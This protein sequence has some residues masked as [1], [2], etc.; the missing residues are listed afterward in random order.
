M[1]WLFAR[2]IILD[3]TVIPHLDFLIFLLIQLVLDNLQMQ[4]DC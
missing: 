1:N 3:L 2:S 4:A